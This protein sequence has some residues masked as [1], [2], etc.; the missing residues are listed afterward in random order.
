MV[1]KII[2]IIIGVLV[3]ITGIYYYNTEKND[4]ESRKIYTAVS[5]IGAAVAV[6]SLILLL[7]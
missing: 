1:V 4:S 2:G 6:I 7:V 5:C 3:A